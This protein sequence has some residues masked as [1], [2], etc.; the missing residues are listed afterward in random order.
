MPA[1]SGVISRPLFLR[2]WRAGGNAAA[3]HFG[4]GDLGCSL[5]DGSFGGR[6]GVVDGEASGESGEVGVRGERLQL[7]ERLQR[8]GAWSDTG[9]VFAR[10]DGTAYHPMSVSRTFKR[11][12]KRAKA[13]VIRFHD[14]RHAHATTLLK[15]GVHPKVVQ[16]R[17]GHSSIA[18]TL[19]IY[20]HVISGMQEDAASRLGALINGS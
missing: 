5:P 6:P 19:D 3:S 10:E 16:E 18:I 15:L 2:R 1:L 8:G 14:L 11:R 7:E 17:L 4:F 13:P 20:S 9:L 12:V